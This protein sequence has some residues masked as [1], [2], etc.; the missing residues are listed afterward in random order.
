MGDHPARI[1]PN[2]IPV[3]K[4]ADNE[5]FTFKLLREYAN[6]Q[7]Q[8]RGADTITFNCSYLGGAAHRLQCEIGVPVIPTIDVGLRLAEMIALLDIRPKRDSVGAM[9]AQKYRR[10]LIEIRELLREL[11]RCVRNA[12]R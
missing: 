8:S 7:I 11:A 1:Y 3:N 10:T 5:A 2:E 9:R 6:R 4:L 12:L